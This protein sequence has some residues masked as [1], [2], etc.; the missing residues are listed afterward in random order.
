M[1]LAF[2]KDGRRIAIPREG[3]RSR[4]LGTQEK[5]NGRGTRSAITEHPF[6][7]LV[8]RRLRALCLQPFDGEPARKTKSE[9][10]QTP[11]SR[12]RP[13]APPASL[14][15]QPPSHR[16]ARARLD[17]QPRLQVFHEGLAGGA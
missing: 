2:P 14:D 9:E 5:L 13:P 7:E 15:A 16:R 8:C 17:A 10:K 6:A 3:A 1:R 11:P 4:A 12:W